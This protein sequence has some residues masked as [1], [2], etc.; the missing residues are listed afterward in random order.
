[1]R[2]LAAVLGGPEG[3][4]GAAGDALLLDRDDPLVEIEVDVGPAPTCGFAAA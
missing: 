2:R 1:V 4:G 3:D